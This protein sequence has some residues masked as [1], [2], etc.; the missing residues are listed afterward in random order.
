MMDWF[1]KNRWLGTFLSVL[2]V[3][4]LL[5]L[6]LL[7]VAKGSFG[8]ALAHFNDAAA[9][10]MRLERLDPFPSDANYKKMKVHIENY[11]VALQ[12]F[13]EELKTHV[14]PAPSELAPNEFQSR[15]RQAIGATTEKARANKVRLPENFFLGFD[16]YTAALP[17]KDAA[18]LLGQELSQIQML[19]N[20]LI[21]SRVDSITSLKRTPLA[22]E[23]GAPPT[24][25]PVPGRKP[26]A[27]STAGPK[28][29]ERPIVDL[30]FSASPSAMRKVINQIAGANEQ[31]FII[32]T[33]HVR[34]EKDKG[35][36][37]EQAAEAT[38]AAP[39]QPGGLHFI[40]GNEHVETSARIE[41]V[42]IS[43]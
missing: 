39:K 7:F 15:L 17:N 20:I 21:D 26:A 16:E 9:E 14:L 25:T 12:R 13:K 10:R 34:N 11:G 43:Y 40:V 38:T 22:E 23:R 2:G 35:P 41:I 31:F 27:P 18:P 42:R 30:K 28:T 6:I 32:R 36:S 3:A 37:R 8:G 19:M 1:Q 33:L 24:A 5:S 4:T 29:L